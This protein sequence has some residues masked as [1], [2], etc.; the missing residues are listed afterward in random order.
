M[1][2]SSEQPRRWE[3]PRTVTQAILHENRTKT[4]EPQTPWD[5]VANRAEI[6]VHCVN[7]RWVTNLQG[8]TSSMFSGRQGPYKSNLPGFSKEDLAGLGSAQE[9]VAP[10]I[11]SQ[12]RKG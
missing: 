12:S 6:P 2:G 8:V 9:E 5:P 4:E 10:G 3:R 11:S 7:C 1:R